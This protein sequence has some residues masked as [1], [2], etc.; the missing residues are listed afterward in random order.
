MFTNRLIKFRIWDGAEMNYLG[1]FDAENRT[2]GWTNCG[3]LDTGVVSKS[4]TTEEIKSIAIMQSVGLKDDNG[5]EIY[6]GD[7]LKETWQEKYMYGY[8]GE[9]Y[10]ERNRKYVVKYEAPSFNIQPNHQNH[11]I[12]DDF[13]RVVIGN[14]YQ[15]PE[16]L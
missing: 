14:I 5:V 1:N 8:S 11:I 12:M 3:W 9:E 6:E 2:I 4:I 13:R 16:L 10:Y 7:I 15:N